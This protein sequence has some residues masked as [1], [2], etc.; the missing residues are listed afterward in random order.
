MAKALNGNMTLIHVAEP[1]PDQMAYD[2]DPATI[3]AIDPGE[4]RDHIAER[5]HHE[6]QL[7]QQYAEEFR[8]QD[9]KCTALMVQ[10]GTVELLLKEAADL[11]ADFIVVGTHGKG[12]F[13]QLLL[14][15]VSEELIKKSPIPIHVIPANRDE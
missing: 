8:Q 14:G 3:A 5:F 6:H 10:G 13:S 7:I 2:Y 15:S 4:I 1:N 12:M 11:K 9:L